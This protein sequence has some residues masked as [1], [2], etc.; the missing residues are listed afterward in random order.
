MSKEG[1]EKQGKT[2]VDAAKV[3]P[4]CAWLNALAQIL[5]YRIQGAQVQHFIYSS[6]IDVTK[7]KIL[8]DPHK[9]MQG[10]CWLY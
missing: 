1:E 3:S 9:R 8:L 5:R 6:L 7:G 10:V 2:I 4:S